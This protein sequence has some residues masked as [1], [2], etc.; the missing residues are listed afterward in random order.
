[1]NYE[2]MQRWAGS[3]E[4]HLFGDLII[5]SSIQCDWLMSKNIII[6]ILN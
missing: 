2:D 3:S 5:K 1:M 4:E 6:L